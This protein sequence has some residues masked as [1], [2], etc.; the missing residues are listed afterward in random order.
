MDNLQKSIRSPVEV[1]NE[2]YGSDQPISQIHGIKQW[3]LGQK[4]LPH[5]ELTSIVSLEVVLGLLVDFLRFVGAEH[6][7]TPW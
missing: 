3:R 2:L 4:I 1:R 6:L 5:E 7:S